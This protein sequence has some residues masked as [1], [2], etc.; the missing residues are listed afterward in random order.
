MIHDPIDLS[1]IMLKF[2]GGAYPG[3]MH[4]NE[5]MDSMFDNYKQ[6]FKDTA[7]EV[8]DAIHSTISRLS[9]SQRTT[10][11]KKINV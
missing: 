11:L 6:F 8:V 1:K 5:D 2:H 10:N 7:T 9:L 4:F 3:L